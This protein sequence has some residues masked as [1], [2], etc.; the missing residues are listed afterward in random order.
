MNVICTWPC[1]S[2]EES[3]ESEEEQKPKPVT[4]GLARKPDG[5]S[6]SAGQPM[7]EV[8]TKLAAMSQ[9]ALFME[10]LVDVGGGRVQ[11]RWWPR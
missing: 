5:A 11:G 6:G 9:L 3:S 2:F 1:F 10:P 4:K 7:V 8:A